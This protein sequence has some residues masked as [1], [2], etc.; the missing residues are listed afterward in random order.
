MEIYLKSEDCT[1]S[2][3]AGFTEMKDANLK[4]LYLG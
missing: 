4:E 3:L 2:S 1:T